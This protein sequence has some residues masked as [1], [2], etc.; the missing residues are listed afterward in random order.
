LTAQIANSEAA[1]I[2]WM[3]GATIACSSFA[4]TAAKLVY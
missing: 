1:V 3:V 4:F 2:K